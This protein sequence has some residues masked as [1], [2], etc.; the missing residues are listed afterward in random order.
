MKHNR[1]DDVLRRIEAEEREQSRR[2][3][4]PVYA[5]VA[6]VIAGLGATFYFTWKS[7]KAMGDVVMPPVLARKASPARQDLGLYIRSLLELAQDADRRLTTPGPQ[8]EPQV[9]SLRRRLVQLRETGRGLEPQVNREESRVLMAATHAQKRIEQFVNGSL[10][11]LTYKHQDIEIAQRALEKAKKLAVGDEEGAEAVD[12]T[13]I[14]GMASQLGNITKNLAE[15]KKAQETLRQ[16]QAESF[17]DLDAPP[18][19]N[20]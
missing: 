2:A 15:I 19:A 8:L 13:P 4:A 18:T 7:D 9:V 6:L 12:R 11:A 17:K 20:K 14:L 5:I 3:W 1:M 16:V 10:S